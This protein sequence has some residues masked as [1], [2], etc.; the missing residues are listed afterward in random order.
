MD[1]S[2]INTVLGI[3]FFDIRENDYICIVSSGFSFGCRV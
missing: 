3:R 1:D 2:Q